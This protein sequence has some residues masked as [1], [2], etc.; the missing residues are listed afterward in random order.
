[1]NT[2]APSR[3]AVS[4]FSQPGRPLEHRDDMRQNGKGVSMRVLRRFAAC[5]V[6]P[7]CV[8]LLIDIADGETALRENSSTA[9][10]RPG[11][12]APLF[13]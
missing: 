9:R 10:E 3:A 4:S 13:F 12:E 8:G 6:W 5:E 11:K 2:A 1:M 7:G